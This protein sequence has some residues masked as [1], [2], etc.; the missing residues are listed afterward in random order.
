LEKGFWLEKG[1]WFTPAPPP[2]WLGPT[3]LE[4]TSG[5]HTHKKFK[6]ISA[7]VAQRP[8]FLRLSILFFHPFLEKIG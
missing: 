3:F 2:G 5:E 8:F 1:S 7:P 6:K 4:K